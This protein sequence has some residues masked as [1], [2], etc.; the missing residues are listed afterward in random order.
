MDASMVKVPLDSDIKEG[1]IVT[2]FGFDEKG[3]PINFQ[4]F[5][6][7]TGLSVEETISRFGQRITRVYH[8]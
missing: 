3:N 1:D 2:I 7:K 5:F 8:L 4:E 6:S